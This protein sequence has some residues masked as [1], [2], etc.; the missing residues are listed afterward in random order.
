MMPKLRTGLLIACTMLSLSACS[1]E[2]GSTAITTI[3]PLAVRWTQEI[4][5]GLDSLSSIRSSA[6]LGVY[7]SH[8]LINEIVFRSALE[9]IA[10]QASI[11]S[12]TGEENDES[13]ALLETLGAILQVDVPDM[14]NRSAVRSEAFDTYLQNLQNI[15]ARALAHLDSLEQQRGELTDQ[16]GDI[17]VEVSHAQTGLSRALRDKDYSTA[18]DL[19]KQLIEGKSELAEFDA[20]IDEVRSIIRLFEDLI[21]V[22]EKR[23]E[24]M[25]ANREALLAGISVVDLPGADDMGL[26][27]NARRSR[28]SIFD[29]GS[30][31]AGF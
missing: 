12:D 21:D 11:M 24:V 28:G 22:G 14:L 18:N 9:G 30:F 6:L 17:R 5:R 10:A 16:R 19:Q 29:P 31:D 23:A 2:T 13:F 27:E 25:T 15:G 1:K 20:R 8:H 26:I 7:I 3:A 4:A